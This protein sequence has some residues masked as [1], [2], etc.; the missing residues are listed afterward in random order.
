MPLP[1]P[2]LLRELETVDD[3]ATIEV[4]AEALAEGPVAPDALRRLAA[5]E[6]SS[7]RRAAVLALA[8]RHDPEGRA[9][10]EACL[11][12][13]TERVR[14]DA[15][16]ALAT[17]GDPRSAQ[18]VAATLRDPR[19]GVRAAAAQA[20]AG[21]GG[22]PSALAALLEGERV[23]TVRRAALDA[24]ARLGG[25]EALVAVAV[26]VGRE[27][28][29]ALAALAADHVVALAQRGDP[30]QL[31]STFRRVPA[32]SR[33]A[34][35]DALG[36]DAALG[37]WGRGVE[38]GSPLARITA[39]LRA[40]RP[41]PQVLARFGS[42]LTARATAASAPRTHGRERE[43][44]ALLARLGRDGSKSVV[45][46]GPAGAGKTAIVHELARRLAAEPVLVPTAVLEATTG[47]VIS[48]TRFLGEWQTRLKELTDAVRAPHRAVWYV[49]DVNRLVDAGTTAHSDESFA[50]MLGPAVERGDVVIIGESTP[51]AFRRGLDR[52][53]NFGRLFQRLAVDETDRAATLGVLA[54]VRDDLVLEQ[55]RRGVDLSVT[56]A[57]LEHALDLAQDH[58]PALARP[59]NAIHLLRE[60]VAATVEGRTGAQPQASP[61]HTSVHPGQS[62]GWAWPA[63]AAPDLAV[64]HV[65]DPSSVLRTL[66]ALTGV[67]AHL[68]DDTVPLDLEATARFFHE[69]VLGQDGAVEA[70]VD[71]ISLIKAGLADPTRPLGALLFVGPT[72]VGK[73]EM[74]KAIA[75]FIFGDAQ[76]RLV[77][78]DLGEFKE[79]DAHRRLVGDPQALDPASRQ[80]LLTAPVRERPFSVVLLDEVEKAHRNVF[81]LLLPLLAE[82]RLVDEQG[83]VTDF[84]RAII[85]MT[86]NLGSDLREDL[87]LGFA[88]GADAT[89]GAKVLRALE[90]AFR[91]E[92]VNRI[93]RVVGFAPLTTEVM[94]RLTRR[95]V[96]RVL[97][98]RGIVRRGVVVETDDAVIGTLCRDGF[99][100]RYGARPLKRRVEE[101]LLKPLARALLQV[102]P[103]EAGAG[104][105]SAS[106]AVSS[107][108]NPAI[109]RLGVSGERVVS[110]VIRPS[111]E[112][113]DEPPPRATARVKDA[114]GRLVAADD[115][116]ARVSDLFERVVALADN[117]EGQRLRE[118]KSHL[119][120]LSS[121]ADFW[122]DKAR[123]SAVLSE[124]AALEQA[125]EAPAKL[126]RRLE[127]LEESVGRLRG[128]SGESRALHDVVT[129]V[130]EAG[131]DVELAEYA[132]R[133][134]SARDRG[135]AWLL[136]RLAEDQGI[137]P[138]AKDEPFPEDVVTAMARM[139]MRYAKRKGLAARVVF[140]GLTRAGAVR[141]AGLRVEGPCAFGL[142]KGE[143]GLHQWVHRGETRRDKRATLARVTVFPPAEAPLRPQDVSRERRAVR[144]ETG[145]L[146]EKPRSHL[147]LTH[148]ATLVAVDGGVDADDA[149]EAALEL[150]AARVAHARRGDKEPG[151]VRRYVLSN[152]PVMRDLAT[153]V[154][155][156]LDRALEGEL[157]EVVLARLPR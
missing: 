150:L 85:V 46:V 118:R 101:L 154:K 48:G 11:A 156:H 64:R 65:V 99:S 98:R 94:R 59:G 62:G 80:G 12:D 60:A 4:A 29:R 38:P 86:S 39:E 69:R 148:L 84:R 125:I 40:L 30:Q 96:R 122:S 88:T 107:P 137:D 76:D 91:P 89:A 104:A 34:L 50:A 52:H 153:G 142:L 43:V 140:E 44:D 102:G 2:D 9:V 113:D 117:L 77:R 146:I 23:T 3:D 17:L 126:E 74:A 110:E 149:E 83:R 134:P 31:L 20:L 144:G 151:V 112:A 54:G 7:V 79:P 131:R 71:L 47:E 13:A 111:A 92:F 147:V 157:D 58:L 139:L 42:D 106:Q 93:G 35:A 19:P 15:C 119:L 75:E 24:L 25:D 36:V 55:A 97:A 21:L 128:Q 138:G 14:Q 141:E 70:V 103:E 37:E 136:L 90:D 124:V 32:A 145:V 100:E 10:I 72:G 45:L 26:H 87:G 108:P 57:A 6:R 135:D 33:R 68:L 18:P 61:P 73:T 41:D 67:P 81:D 1:V 8:R 51:D 53:P 5:D 78:V 121:A 16:R 109:I 120:A 95:E 27:D 49:P 132:A 116:A 127:R 133:C 63:D 114:T 129:R 56:D 82:G 28:D 115:L 66:S 143:A 130:A 22:A 105:P 152:N 155:L 123:A